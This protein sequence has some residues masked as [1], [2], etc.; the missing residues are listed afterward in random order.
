MNTD[1]LHEQGQGGLNTMSSITSV[2][3]HFLLRSA[4]QKERACPIGEREENG[5]LNGLNSCNRQDRNLE[6]VVGCV[7]GSGFNEVCGW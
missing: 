5:F 7:D 1:Y 3:L 2:H 6:G 4:P